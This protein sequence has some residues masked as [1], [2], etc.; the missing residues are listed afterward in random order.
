MI[1]NAVDNERVIQ[2]TTTKDNAQVKVIGKDGLVI[3]EFVTNV[4]P[5][6]GDSEL[7]IININE[8]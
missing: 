3:D 6:Y 2:I 7:T 5:R 1:L 4:A 8:L